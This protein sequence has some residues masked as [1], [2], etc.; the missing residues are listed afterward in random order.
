L[1]EIAREVVC[2]GLSRLGE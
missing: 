1:K 2:G